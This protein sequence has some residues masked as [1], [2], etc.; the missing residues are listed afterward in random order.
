[1]KSYPSKKLERGTGEKVVPKGGIQMFT[2]KRR[3]ALVLV[4]IMVVSILISSVIAA[5][6]VASAHTRRQDKWPH[7][8]DYRYRRPEP[9]KTIRIRFTDKD[10]NRLIAIG[11]I[12]FLTKAISEAG[13]CPREVAY[14]SPP[15]PRYIYVPSPQPTYTPS[16]STTIVTVRNA[17]NW[18]VLVNINGMELNLYPGYEQ[19]VSW[20]YTGRGHYIKAR[21]YLGPYHQESVGTY[22]G[23]LIG[24]QIPWRLNFDY[25]SFASSV[26]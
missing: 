16:V 19:A 3:T 6:P 22:Q 10:I 25:G 1:L 26:N 9:K 11:G 8:R 23:N 21:A 4:G 5:A 17:T 20:T 12:Y 24:Y 2:G 14:V 13:K 7:H 15:P 18:Y